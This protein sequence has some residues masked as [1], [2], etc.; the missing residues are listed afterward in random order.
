MKKIFIIICIFQI[1]KGL[2]QCD[3]SYTYFNQLPDN[4]TILVGDSCLNNIDIHVLDSI[5]I[6]NGLIYDSPLELGTQTWFNGRMIFIL[7]HSL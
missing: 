2:S 5:E 4:V 3:S 7:Y 6:K 1:N